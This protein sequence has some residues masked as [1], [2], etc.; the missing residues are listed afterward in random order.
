MDS[1]IEGLP[2]LFMSKETPGREH[3]AE[4]TIQALMEKLGGM[5]KKLFYCAVSG[6]P[7]YFEKIGALVRNNGGIFFGVN[8]PDSTAG[9]AWNDM[10]RKLFGDGHSLY[11]RLEDDFYLKSPLDLTPFF[12]AF[13]RTPTLSM[14][15]LGL[16][17]IGLKLWSTSDKE[18]IY[19]E[20]LAETQ[21]AYSGNPGLIHRRMHDE[22]GYY[23]ERK[24]P[25]DIEIE[26]DERVRDRIRAG[27]CQIWWPLSLGAYGTY[28][29]WDHIGE[30]KSY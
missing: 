21:Y 3:I 11:L 9:Q 17:P 29:P 25:G 13:E 20:C 19:F 7:E 10:L 2:I 18:N 30:V 1:L 23:H 5:Y 8:Y 4:H 24:N 15:R 22:V 6:T 27:K 16:M 14:I 28:G 12:K 26:F